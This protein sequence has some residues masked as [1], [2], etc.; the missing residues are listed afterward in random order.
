MQVSLLVQVP[1]APLLVQCSISLLVQAGS[2]W[3]PIGAIAG[4]VIG[5]LFGHKERKHETIYQMMQMRQWK[6]NAHITTNNIYQWKC[7]VTKWRI[8][9]KEKEKKKR[10]IGAKIRW[11][12]RSQLAEVIRDLCYGYG[13]ICIQNRF[14]VVR[15]WNSQ[16]LLSSAWTKGEGM[17]QAYH[18]KVKDTP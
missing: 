12:W 13:R 3:L 11:L 10:K 6:A 5:G 14:E 16:R 17:R 15:R 8:S 18:D 1:P 2:R 4:F 7:S 9:N